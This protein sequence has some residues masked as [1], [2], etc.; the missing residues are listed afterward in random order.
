MNVLSTGWT[1]PRPS[2]LAIGV[3][4]GVHQG[5]AAVI[6]GLV[7]QCRSSGLEVGV[8]TFDPHPVEVLAPDYAPDLLMPVPRRIDLLK[9]LGVGW[10]GI[11]DLGEIRMM[12]PQ[13]FI[14]RILVGRASARLVSV[15]DD[16]RF[17]HDRAGDVH[18]LTEEGR[19]HGFEVVSVDLVSDDGGVISSSRIRRLVSAGQVSKAAVLLGRPHRLTGPVI[20]GDARGRLLGFPTANLALPPDLAVPADGIYAVRVSGTVSGEGVAS[21]GVRPTFGEDGHR[22]LEVHLFD[23]TGDLYETILDVDFVERLRGEERFQSVDDLVSQM[24]RDASDARQA[25]DRRK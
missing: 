16:F 18:T 17:G 22:L 9:Q 6:S 11:L 4:D 8:L 13:E 10:V 19:R 1:I 7:E 21:L 25:L 3:F 14:T 5:H 12:S 2:G 20:R 23:F 15:G 24:E